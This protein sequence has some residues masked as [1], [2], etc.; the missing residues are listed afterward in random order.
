MKLVI[1]HFSSRRL[2]MVQTR[3]QMSETVDAERREAAIA[4]RFQDCLSDSYEPY[5]EIVQRMRRTT[6]GLDSEL[7]VDKT[8][9]QARICRIRVVH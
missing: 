4:Q 2:I 6:K 3:D 7:V 8:G 1:K 9:F 5:S